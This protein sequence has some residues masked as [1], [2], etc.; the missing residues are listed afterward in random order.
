MRLIV[1]MNSTEM[2]PIKSGVYPVETLVNYTPQMLGYPHLY[3]KEKTPTIDSICYDNTAT[4]FNL[5]T[6][7]TLWLFASLYIPICIPAL[8]RLALWVPSTLTN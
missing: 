5:L 7:H 4:H 8:V 3:P 6:M 1:A 2:W